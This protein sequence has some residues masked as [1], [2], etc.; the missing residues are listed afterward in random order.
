MTTN[1]QSTKPRMLTPEELGMLVKVFREMRQWS[2]D[3]LGA[4]SGLSV[5]TVQRV[6]TGN[7]SGLDT[8]RALARAFELEDIDAFNKPYAIPTD[9]EIKAAKEKF[10]QENIT[11][12]AIPLTGKELAGLVETTTMDLS[13]PAFELTREADE[14]FA[15]LIDYFREY[16]DCA[17]LYSE[18]DKFG[19]YDDLQ[20]RIDEL[21]TL[22]VSLCYATRKLVVKGAPQAEPWPT[23]ALY[24]VAFPVGKEPSEFATP[25]AVGVGW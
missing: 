10:E 25:R 16:R 20:G 8:R 14:K 5:R 23:T 24:V 22:G 17:D 2:Q 15:E 18:H 4:I 21:R 7:P 19:V 13:A 1:G 6:E 12:P 9:E 3:Q 11:L